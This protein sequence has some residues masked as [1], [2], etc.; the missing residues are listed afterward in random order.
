MLEGIIYEW[1]IKFMN[2]K[3]NEW[4]AELKEW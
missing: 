4:M 1:M 2:E 3:F